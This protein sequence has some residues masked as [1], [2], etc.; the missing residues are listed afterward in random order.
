MFCLTFIVYGSAGSSNDI[1]Q[2]WL[3]WDTIESKHNPVI[4][5]QYCRLLGGLSS[6]ILSFTSAAGAPYPQYYILTMIVIAILYILGVWFLDIHYADMGHISKKN[7][8]EEGE[9]DGK[10]KVKG[11]GKKKKKK[12]KSKPQEKENEEEGLV[13]H[14]QIEQSNDV[15]EQEEEKQEKNEKDQNEGNLE[16]EQEHLA[17]VEDD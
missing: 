16:Q 13:K 17:A 12:S 4:F 14:D 11:K 6:G 3:T 1:N 15:K 10:R 2:F 5:V 8:D 7:D 9:K